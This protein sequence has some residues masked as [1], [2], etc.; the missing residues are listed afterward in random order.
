[1]YLFTYPINTYLVTS[2]MLNSRGTSIFN[3]NEVG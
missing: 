3:L 1:V 2:I